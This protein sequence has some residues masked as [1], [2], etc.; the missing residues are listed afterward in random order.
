QRRG[1][2]APGPAG[3]QIHLRREPVAQAQPGIAATIGDPATVVPVVRRNV[4]I[5]HLETDLV[6][7]RSDLRLETLATPGQLQVGSQPAH[8][9]A[10]VPTQPS[11][12]PIPITQEV[13][14][15]LAVIHR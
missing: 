3:V 4:A 12:H 6:P 7:P 2:E 1:F 15:P 13:L 9:V 14:V 8:L 10:L 5:L 11:P